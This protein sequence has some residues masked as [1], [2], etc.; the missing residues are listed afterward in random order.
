MFDKFSPKSIIKDM[1]NIF[2][3]SAGKKLKSDIRLFYL[4]P[5][6]LAICAFIF[7][8]YFNPDTVMALLTSF[9]IF[10]ALLLNLLVVLF[11]VTKNITQEENE[12][13][14]KYIPYHLIN[15]PIFKRIT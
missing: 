3:D 4:L 1:T 9:S 11:A 7:I 10:V 15:R 13:K 8:R 5:V 14:E 12:K 6:E 2:H